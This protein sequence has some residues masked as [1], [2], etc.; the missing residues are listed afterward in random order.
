LK[1]DDLGPQRI[2]LRIIESHSQ[3]GNRTLDKRSVEIR[4][5][6]GRFEPYQDI[7]KEILTVDA[8]TVRSTMRT[9]ARDVNGSKALVQLTEEDKHILPGDDS[10]IVRMTYNQDVNGRLQPVQREMV[11]TKKI[12][13]NLE[14]TN[15]TVMLPS[16]NGGLAPVSKTHELRKRAANDT[17]EIEKTTWLTDVNGKW[18]V[19]EVRQ[20][21]NTKGQTDRTIE[22]HVSRIDSEG[23]VGEVSRVVSHESESPSGEKRSVVEAFS[24][25][26][27]GTTRDGSLHLVERKTSVESSNL[28]GVR[29]NQQR[30]EQT[31]P[32]DPGSGLRLSVLVDGRVVPGPAG[33]QSTVTIRAR[34]SNGNVG[35]VSVDTTKSDRI[36]T[37]QVQRT[38]SEKP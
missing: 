12:G 4:R 8:F 25:D 11:E 33:E 37:I 22:E 32:G 14:E 6:D 27:P 10:N 1:S 7:E 30:I 24:I 15:T 9:F 26:V 28:T 38:P 17:I 35:I 36:P 18:Q 20:A 31:S 5:N 21:T 3:S 19:S 2:P 13:K 29:A 34:D 23:K 16:V